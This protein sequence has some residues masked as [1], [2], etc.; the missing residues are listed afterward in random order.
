MDV[1][2]KHVLIFAA[3][4]LNISPAA[5]RM[6]KR[7]EIIIL[8]DEKMIGGLLTKSLSDDNLEKWFEKLKPG[9]K[10]SLWWSEVKAS[11]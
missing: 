10:L 11:Y 5:Y 8:P 2:I 7:S 9:Q 6:V 3:E 1:S 4:L